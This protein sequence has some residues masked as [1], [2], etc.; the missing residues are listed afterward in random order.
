MKLAYITKRLASFAAAVLLTVSAASL[1]MVAFADYPNE[2]HNCIKVSEF[3]GTHS[4]KYNAYQVFKLKNSNYDIVQD[5]G[6]GIDVNEGL[7][8]DLKKI[9]EFTDNNCF[10]DSNGKAYSAAEIARKC[11][12]VLSKE[13]DNSSLVKTFA[14]TMAKYKIDTN[15]A[16]VDNETGKTPEDLSDGYWMVLG[17]S[18]KGE[19][20]AENVVWTSGL[21]KA[22][23]GG[24]ADSVNV[25]E[26]MAKLYVPTVEIK[27]LDERSDTKS[28][29]DVTDAT[30]GDMI[31]FRLYAALPAD[32]DSYSDYYAQFKDSLNTDVYSVDAESFKCYK[33]SGTLGYALSRNAD[34]TESDLITDSDG[35]CPF[36]YS[37]AEYGFDISCDNLK[38]CKDKSGNT[39]S[40][41][42]MIIVEYKAKLCNGDNLSISPKDTGN[43]NKAAFVYSNNQNDTDSTGVTTSDEVKVFTYEID[44]TKIDSVDKNSKLEGAAFALKNNDGQYARFEN[45]NGISKIIEWEDKEVTSDD[46]EYL[47]VSDDKGEFK[48][49]GIGSGEYV[50]EE[51]KA[52]DGYLSKNV[53]FKIESELTSEVELFNDDVNPL[54][55]LKYLYKAEKEGADYEEVEGAGNVNTGVITISIENSSYIAEAPETGGMGRTILYICGGVIISIAVISLVVK[56]RYQLS[57]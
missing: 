47:A 49:S 25:V 37:W 13:D 4:I 15:S 39:F 14:K 38:D 36:E 23:K 44:A 10:E 32:Y 53:A 50:L 31:S 11:A 3:N 43:S 19:N 17:E 26:V 57:N 45:S 48:I 20:Q 5:W 6:N 40:A 52:P 54:E 1:S 42:D 27:V 55:A 56:K 28:W 7:I 21:L 16:S 22:A 33:K 51:L 24:T 34:V 12:V 35:N 29:Q 2:G 30:V 9:T 18:Y 46:S 41:G 8:N